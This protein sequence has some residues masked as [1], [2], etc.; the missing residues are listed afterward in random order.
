MARLDAGWAGPVGVSFPS[1]PRFCRFRTVGHGRM[2]RRCTCLRVAM[3]RVKC[4]RRAATEMSYLDG[5]RRRE[6]GG[7]RLGLPAAVWRRATPSPS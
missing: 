5:N 3:A 6:R 7:K 4:N 2:R 1:S